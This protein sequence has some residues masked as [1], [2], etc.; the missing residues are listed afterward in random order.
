MWLLSQR[1]L[2]ILPGQSSLFDCTPCFFID[3]YIHTP[4]AY[5][6]DMSDMKMASPTMAMATAT[7][8]PTMHMDMPHDSMG[9]GMMMSMADMAIVFF[10]SANTPLYT[11]SWTP[12]TAGQYAGICIF[13]VIL[14]IVCRALLVLR[15]RFPALMEKIYARNHADILSQPL[16]DIDECKQA[17]KPH[18]PWSINESLLRGVL[19]TILAGVGYML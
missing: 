18:K 5:T 9:S 12:K 15:C 2:G 4:P 11:Q 8:S 6:M 14:A 16:D 19:D 3:R 13:L 1:W 7:P 10:N 17:Q